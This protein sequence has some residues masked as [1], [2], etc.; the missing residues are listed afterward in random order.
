MQ[1]GCQV[2][3]TINIVII[4][5]SSCFTGMEEVEKKKSKKIKNLKEGHFNALK[6]YINFII[7]FNK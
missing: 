4:T 5:N 2:Q 1:I 3:P 6:S 7:Y